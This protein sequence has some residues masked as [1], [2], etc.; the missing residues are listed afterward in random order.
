M[1]LDDVAFAVPPFV[2]AT[3]AGV[4]HITTNMPF[5]YD[6]KMPRPSSTHRRSPGYSGVPHPYHYLKRFSSSNR[7]INL[8][9]AVAVVLTSP[10]S[11]SRMPILICA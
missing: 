3:V 4:M 10:P 9:I 8:A 7:C 11:S 2:V 6:P 5:P 1:A